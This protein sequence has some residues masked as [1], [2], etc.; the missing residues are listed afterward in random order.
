MELMAM[1]AATLSGGRV[2]TMWI[3]RFRKHGMLEGDTAHNSGRSSLISS[4]VRPWEGTTPVQIHG[5]IRP[6]A[7]AEVSATPRRLPMRVIP[8]LVLADLGTFSLA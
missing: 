5:A 2:S 1:L 8:C 3:S 6:G 4:I 7:P